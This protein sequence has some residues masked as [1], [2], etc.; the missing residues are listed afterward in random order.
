LILASFVQ[1]GVKSKHNYFSILEIL[2]VSKISKVQI[3]YLLCV[4]NPRERISQG[5]VALRGGWLV[6]TPVRGVEAPWY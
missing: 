4:G 3:W 5:W 6:Q 2:G 1:T